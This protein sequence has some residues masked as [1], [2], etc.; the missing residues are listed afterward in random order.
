MC[1]RELGACVHVHIRVDTAWGTR[2]PRRLRS[3]PEKPLSTLM[4]FV[5]DTSFRCLV[6]L[7]LFFFFLILTRRRKRKALGAEDGPGFAAH[8]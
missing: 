5:S 6:F 4:H 1:G 7:F 3:A 2:D 8:P